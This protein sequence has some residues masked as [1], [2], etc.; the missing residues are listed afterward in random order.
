MLSHSPTRGLWK[1]ILQKPHSCAFSTTSPIHNTAA[2]ASAAS[3]ASAFLSRFQSQGPQIRK[4]VLDANQLQLL[5]LTLNRPT[6]H[7][8]PPAYHLVYFT[9]AFLET[10]L[11][12][13]GTDMSYNP[14]SPF[15][16]RMW[17][18]G[19]V[20]WPRD[21]R[22]ELNLLRVGQEVKETTTVLSS[23]PK[24]VR[25]TGEA[26][27]VVGVEKTFSNEDG[28]AVV[29]RRNWVFREALPTNPP[30]PKRES[31]NL[32][33]L[34][35]SSNGRTK[36]SELVSSTPMEGVYKRPYNRSAVTLFRFSALTFNPHKIHYSVPWS[37][38]VE[39]HK[40]IVVHGPLNLISMLDFWRDLRYEQGGKGYADASL[41]VPQSIT[42]R[43]T[44]P[45]YADEDYEIVLE[46]GAEASTVNIY[47]HSGVVSMKAE[48]RG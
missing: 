20:S 18:G 24:V 31:N 34:S 48:I 15:T 3:I 17:A 10:E 36:P 44:S 5:S 1:T 16:R 45:L 4:Q 13:D 9:P 23:E 28:V 30:Q 19:E 12:A 38:D 14:E 7:S 37:Q 40:N 29:D 39:G 41:I 6:L 32:A 42:Y 47:N 35:Q 33:S 27:I 26:M 43:A 2:A 21:A 8:Y 46:K 11:G 25:K 22:G